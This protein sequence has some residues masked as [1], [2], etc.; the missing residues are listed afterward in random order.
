MTDTEILAYVRFWLGNLPATI[1][2]DED[3]LKLLQIVRLRYPQATDCQILYYLTVAVLEFLLRKDNQGSA[4]SVG[5]GELKSRTEKEGDVTVTEQYDVGSSAGKVAGWEAILE[6]LLE[7]PDSIGCPVFPAGT[8]RRGTVIIGGAEMGGYDR[9]YDSVNRRD[10]A[11]YGNRAP[12]YSP[13]R[14][15]KY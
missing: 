8:E 6:R 11:A 5:T 12:S 7:D 1:I 10:K 9:V 3:M 4:G 15:N 2:S 14:P 13:W